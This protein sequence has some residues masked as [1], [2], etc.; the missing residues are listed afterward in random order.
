MAGM[1]GVCVF[2]ARKAVGAES[3][4]FEHSKQFTFSTS[5]TFQTVTVSLADL[6]VL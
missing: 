1:Q 6:G 3:C 4:H 2:G 5:P